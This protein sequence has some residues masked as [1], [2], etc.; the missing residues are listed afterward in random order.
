M[1]R[2]TTRDE[3]FDKFG[4]T[5]FPNITGEMYRSDNTFL[6]TLRILLSNRIP[7]GE[8]VSLEFKSSFDPGAINQNNGAFVV[9]SVCPTDIIESFASID[10]FERV[11]KV[12]DFYRASFRAECFID[13][14]TKRV[15]LFVEDLNIRMMHFVQTG[16]FAMLPWYF[17]REKGALPDELALIK[18]LQKDKPFEY[19]SCVGKFKKGLDVR[20]L[21]IKSEVSGYEKRAV[22][23]KIS[24]QEER[25]S[26]Y[27]S[28]IQSLQDRMT[29][30]IRSMNNAID[31]LH[32]L[33]YRKSTGEDNDE[34]TS[35]FLSNKKLYPCNVGDS[36][37][38]YG[39]RGRLSYYD[40]DLAKKMVTNTSTYLYNNVP[41]DCIKEARRLFEL[42]FLENKI[43]V[44]IAAGFRV[45]TEDCCISPIS[46]FVREDVKDTDFKDD[47]ADYIPNYHID[48]YSCLGNNKTIINEL[49]NDGNTMMAIAQSIAASESLN[50]T[51]S[52]VIKYFVNEFIDTAR[53]CLI[54][55][56]GDNVTPKQAMAWI[57]GGEK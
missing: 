50:L 9:Y 40:M 45:N 11:Q 19:I 35:F 54:L 42:I 5:L 15:C 49:M 17:P 44:K 6:T 22:D 30:T 12:S 23:D 32:G 3:V 18:S 13:E 57:K 38:I 8:S 37:I 46:G 10:G 43:A 56:N 55:P 51:D 36:G 48:E 1:F 24:R 2:N 39:V 29:D 14:S 21:M 31:I 20:E 26:R 53:K 25:I 34:L 47:F 28:D 27:R 7:D 33:E 41:A 16:I 4:D 52:T